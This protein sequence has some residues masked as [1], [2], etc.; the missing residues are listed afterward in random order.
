MNTMNKLPVSSCTPRRFPW[1][2]SQAGR[3]GPSPESRRTKNTRLLSLHS[4]GVP[5][6]PAPSKKF[7]LQGGLILAKIRWSPRFPAAQHS[8]PVHCRSSLC[9]YHC[10]RILVKMNSP[11]YLCLFQF[12]SRIFNSLYS[13]EQG[14]LLIPDE[15]AV[16]VHVR[17][18]NLWFRHPLR[19]QRFVS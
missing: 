7:G 10:L 4:L 16:M 1:R 11:L 14:V 15:L 17:V 3:L 8:V 12:T 13:F 6:F 9:Q 18:R 2:K 5:S 19:V